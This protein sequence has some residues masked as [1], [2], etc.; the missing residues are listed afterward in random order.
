[1]AKSDAFRDCNK[2]ER[3]NY[4]LKTSSINDCVHYIFVRLNPALKTAT[5]S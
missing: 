3:G 5:M 1:M 2:K 4:F